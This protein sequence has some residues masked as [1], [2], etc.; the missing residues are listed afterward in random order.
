MIRA[1][2][3]SNY[4]WT[5]FNFRL[6]LIRALEK[7]GIEVHVQTQYDGY[8]QRLGLENCRL[9]PLSI[10]RTGV[11]PVRDLLTAA[12]IG[13]AMRSI[14]ADI[15]LF[16]TIKPVIYGGMAATLHSVP[17]ICNV[18][19]LGAAFG[20]PAWLR[21]AARG[22]YRI[23][24]SK[25]SWVFFQN[26]DDMELFLA[27]GL[28]KAAN[29]S[30]L[31]GSGVDLAR[32]Q[33]SAFP[34][35]RRPVFL[36]VARLLRE[37]GVAE[38]AG[39]ARIVKRRHP[40]AVFRLLGPLGVQNPSAISRSEIEGW[41]LDGA[42]EYLGES[43]DVRPFIGEADCVVLPSYYREGVPRVLLEASAMA[44]P[45][46]STDHVG[47]RDAVD[48]GVTGF[49]CRKRDAADL[50]AK[51]E[52]LLDMPPEDR[53]LMGL[54]GREK[55]RREFDEEIVISRYIAAVRAASGP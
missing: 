49:L 33:A 34:N 38:F 2:L 3:V 29:A 7:T 31:P 44:R 26:T 1:L 15:C 42:I 24:L 50:A 5:I 14:R 40:D 32:F 55:M 23:G 45:V 9:H 19:G 16:F 11:N 6:N 43:D 48:D 39:A 54:R 51:M 30:L 27:G 28:A 12:S 4:A 47:C 41:V 52:M 22:L 8:E 46:I 21:M 10:D 36:L 18:T 25:A 20:G 35:T 13:K 37:K 53:A 17:Y